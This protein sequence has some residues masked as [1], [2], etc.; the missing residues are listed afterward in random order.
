MTIWSLRRT[1]SPGS[2]SDAAAFVTSCMEVPIGKRSQKARACIS[3]RYS[4]TS[5]PAMAAIGSATSA[6]THLERDRKSTRLNSSHLV[7]SYAVFCLKKKSEAEA[8]FRDEDR[9]APGLADK[10]LGERQERRAPDLPFLQVI[11]ALRC[12]GVVVD[13]ERLHVGARR[14]DDRRLVLRLDVGELCDRAVDALDRTGLAAFEDRG[15]RGRVAPLHVLR[16]VCLGLQLGVLPGEAED[17]RLELGLLSCELR[18]LR[19]LL[20]KF[21]LEF[22]KALARLFRGSPQLL[23][24][25]VRVVV[26]NLVRLAGLLDLGDLGLEAGHRLFRPVPFEDDPLD[27][28]LDLV[29]FIVER[30]DLVLDPED[31]RVALRGELV[32]V[33]KVFVGRLDLFV[34]FADARVDLL[35]LARQGVRLLL[36]L[37]LIP[38]RFPGLDAQLFQD[39]LRGLNPVRCARTFDAESVQLLV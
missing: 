33:V 4:T 25:P 11:D 7:I 32:H 9:L 6:A 14:S 1:R 2:P 35:A 20:V 3:A 26:L 31:L 18:F 10:H 15:D 16:D 39:L 36:D 23:E 34:Q 28:L 38:V 12:D 30:N 19:S 5:I 27:A 13:D 22:L 29:D 37:R 8:F 21:L 17:R 24:L